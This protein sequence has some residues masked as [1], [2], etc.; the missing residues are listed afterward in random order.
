MG[1]QDDQGVGIPFLLEKPETFNL[2]N[3][4][5]RDMI[6]VSNIMHEVKKVERGSFFF[7]SDNTRISQL[8]G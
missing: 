2:V 6:Q 1:N 7:F 8:N 5:I 3:K 4:A